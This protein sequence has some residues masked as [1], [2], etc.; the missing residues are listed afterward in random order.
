[1]NRFRGG[2][3]LYAGVSATPLEVDMGRLRLSAGAMVGVAT[4]D[5]G[6]YAAAM[7]QLSNSRLNLTAMAVATLKLEDRKTGWGVQAMV[8]PPV[9]KNTVGFVGLALT[10]KL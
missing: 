7:P 3:T 4:T 10:Q 5:K 8:A 2:R 9:G 1:M 6:S